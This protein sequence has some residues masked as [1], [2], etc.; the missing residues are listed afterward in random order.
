MKGLKKVFLWKTQVTKK[1]V[2]QF[3][4][5]YPNIEVMVGY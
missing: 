5:Q 3:A 2:G 1:G 4:A